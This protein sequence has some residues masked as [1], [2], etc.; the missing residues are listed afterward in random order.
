M[1]QRNQKPSTFNRRQAL[2]AGVAAA[3]GLG[4]NR[5]AR[6]T[7]GAVHDSRPNIILLVTDDQRAD[8]LSCA[9]NTVLHTP[10]IDALAQTGIRF[11]NSFATTAICMSSRASILTG[12]YTRQHG[13][14]DFTKPLATSLFEQSY[15]ALLRKSGYVTGFVGKWGIDGGTMPVDDYDFFKG[16]QGQ[17]TYFNPTNGRHLTAVQADQ[18]IEFLTGC[19]SQQPFCLAVSFKAPHVQDEG[20]NLPGIYAKYPYD[21]ALESCYADATVPPV[22]T[23][24]QSPLPSC[25]AGTLNLT[26]EAPDFSPPNYQETMKDLYRLITGVDQAV[27]RIVAELKAR[28][29]ADNTIIL[30]TADHGSF[31]G[32]HGFGGKWLMHEESIR[33]P[34]ILHDPRMPTNLRGTTRNQ[35]VLNLDVPATLLD[36]AGITAPIGM[37]GRSVLPMVSNSSI[38]GRAEWFYENHFRNNRFGPIAASEGIR[39]ANW[40][41]IRYIDTQPVIE[42]LFDLQN[43][44]REEK[45]LADDPDHQPRLLHL[46]TRWQTWTAALDNHS[47][48]KRWVEPVAS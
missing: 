13:I 29:L 3:T 8:S 31:Y 23:R 2:K 34:F 10:N 36:L 12:L 41:Y 30:Y 25:L 42:Q 1:Q 33:T 24:D 11:C 44:P 16:Y 6:H 18:A 43:D 22:L 27:G 7:R 35:M 40:K 46:R 37:Q 14:D 15:P 45:N 48:D 26:R 4:L 9:G 47:V 28:G 19:T 5:L 39:T 17:N 32:E 38:T 20:R 21:R